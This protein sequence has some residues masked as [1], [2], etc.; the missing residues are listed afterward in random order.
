MSRKLYVFQNGRHLLRCG[1][2]SS[3]KM[4]RKESLRFR[5]LSFSLVISPSRWKCNRKC[6][7]LRMLLFIL[8]PSL[9][10]SGSQACITRSSV[11]KS[12]IAF[13]SPLLSLSLLTVLCF[14]IS[15]SYS[16]TVRAAVKAERKS[17]K[18]SSSDVEALSIVA[19]NTD[20]RW[21]FVKVQETPIND[22]WS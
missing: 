1:S 19:A 12:L 22:K 8:S 21:C 10:C 17:L 13:T 18:A 14:C 9:S 5:F 11:I 20:D 16:Y 7:T 6:K 2:I 15:L 4:Y 3:N